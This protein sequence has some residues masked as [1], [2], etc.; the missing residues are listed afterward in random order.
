MASQIQIEAQ[1]FTTGNASGINEYVTIN[2]KSTWE[3]IS[4]LPY[5]LFYFNSEMQPI[6]MVINGYSRLLVP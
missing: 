2:V 5:N 4:E 3:A 1:D 6:Q